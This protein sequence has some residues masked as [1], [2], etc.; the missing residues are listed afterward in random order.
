MDAN[1]L[2]NYVF[3]VG[4]LVGMGSFTYMIVKKLEDILDV[5]HQ[6]EE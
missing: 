2:V 4:I 5:L 1:I 3:F 6:R